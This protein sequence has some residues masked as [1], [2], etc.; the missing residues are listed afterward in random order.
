M[1]DIIGK[2]GDFITSF[3]V[4]SFSVIAKEK[5]NVFF[6]CCCCWPIAQIG[7][8]RSKLLIFIIPR[9]NRHWDELKKLFLA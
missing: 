7:G 8:F 6:H 1:Q 3:F 5:Q 4:W 9:L 2:R